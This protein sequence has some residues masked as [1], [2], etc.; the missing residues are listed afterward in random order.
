M[1][2]ISPVLG[3]RALALSAT[4][5]ALLACAVAAPR[6]RADATI[7]VST[8]ADPGPGGNCTPSN[9]QCTLREA[10]GLVEEG[11]VTGAISIEL[12]VEG[13]I[14]SGAN[15][16]VLEV[17]AGDGVTAVSIAGP[18]PGKLTISGNR[19]TRVFEIVNEL[20]FTLSGVTVA[21]GS[22]TAFA[23]SGDGGA[24]LF[25]RE[26]SVSLDDVRF[27]GNKLE[28]NRSGAAVAIE[29]DVE[30]SVSDSSFAEN[31]SEENAGAI[32]L[33]TPKPATIADTEFEKNTTEE[34]HGGAVATAEGELTV[35]GSTFSENLAQFDGGAI[36]SFGTLAVEGSVFEHNKAEHNG[37]AISTAAGFTLTDSTVAD[38]E[39][40]EYGGG[41]DLEHG[42][43]IEG[44]TISANSIPD[45][46]EPEGDDL[47]EA[48]GGISASEHGTVLLRDS[49][50]ADNAG[51]GVATNGIPFTIRNSTIAGN[52]T[53]F[54]PGAGIE[55]EEFVLQSTIVAGNTRAGDQADCGGKVTSEGDNLLGAPFSE[56]GCEWVSAA[57]DIFGADPELAPLGNYGGPTETMPPQSRES[58]AINQGADPQLT[59]QRGRT[60]PVPG[61]PLQTD[62]GAV[63]VQA[64]VSLPQEPPSISPAG[65]YAVGAELACDPGGWNTDT[66]TD[67]SFAY[68]WI[69]GGE[70]VGSGSSYELTAADAG[71]QVV[72]EVTADNGV[73][74]VAAESEPVEL[75]PA[76]ATLAPTLIPFGDRRLGSGPSD[77]QT[78]T[79]SNTGGV[80]LEITHVD[81]SDES[82]PLDDSDCAGVTLVPGQ[83]CDVEARFDPEEL[84]SAS[85]TVTVETDAG[86]PT[87]TLSGTGTGFVF[88]ASPASVDFGSQ[89]LGTSSAPTE[90]VVS[91][92]GNLPMPIGEVEA[93]GEDGT[94]FRLGEDGCA[95]STVAP[96]GECTVEVSFAPT[97]AGEREA[98]LVISGEGGGNVP[99]AGT[100]TTPPPPPPTPTPP[101]GPEPP[102]PRIGLIAPK[103]PLLVGR[104]G[105]VKLRLLC[106]APAGA[107]CRA[108]LSLR[109]GK[110]NLGGWRGSVAAGTSRQVPVRLSAPARERLA[111][112]GKLVVL[113]ALGGAGEQKLRLLLR[114][115]LS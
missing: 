8:T 30:F 74:P 109:T 26:G 21:D 44:S 42:A 83:S 72:C 78:L 105:L 10:L 9:G 18:G 13:K 80:D 99:L 87:A 15:G 85:S 58:P 111:K 106:E 86:D 51:G 3:R 22:E 81:G 79:V 61:N 56:P 62:I 60:R 66:V 25:A 112:N 50:V 84:G 5:L 93:G 49:T 20:D 43:T 31:T 89:P 98:T 113:A 40:L 45:D 39:A 37:G 47:E 28:S 73:T 107:A 24:G 2:H 64:P 55:G 110:K 71:E 70:T 103:G 12:E 52:S 76:E 48:G 53:S 36:A 35:S 23:F 27:T 101:P 114:P 32:Y 108:S 59:D 115:A 104:K 33:E 95:E 88:A 94:D 91:N 16:G 75:E 38:N 19:E 54:I 11:E 69:V 41:L 6:A 57:G 46:Q 82:F 96:G 97:V 77:P 7:V 67:P 100:G 34:H 92:E 17:E 63:E 65:P 29:G 14:E 90:I 4:L 1:L 68:V 102:A